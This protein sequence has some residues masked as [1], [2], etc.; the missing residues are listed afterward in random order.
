MEQKNRI[1][2][3]SYGYDM[4]FLVALLF[5]TMVHE[6]LASNSFNYFFGP[7]AFFSMVCAQ[8][9]LY[10]FMAMPFLSSGKHFRFAAVTV[11]YVIALILVFYLLDRYWPNQ[12]YHHGQRKS[13]KFI[14]YYVATCM[15]SS[16]M[17]IALSMVRQYYR[18]QEKR[19]KDQVLLSQ[20]A[21]QSLHSQ[22]NP[23]FFFNMLNNLYGVSL[24]DPKRTPDLI[25]QLSKLM[26]YPLEN[27]NRQLVSLLQE[28]EFVESYID[29]ERERSGSQCRISFVLP[30]DKEAVSVLAIAPLLLITLVENAFKHS[31]GSS[32]WFVKLHT[33]LDGNT[34]KLRL[35]NSLP[36]FGPK[37]ESTGIGLSNVRK[38]LD[39]LYPGRHT[40][41]NFSIA[42][43][44]TVFLVLQLTAL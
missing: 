2:L 18:E 40:F 13:M 16:I 23:H 4:F 17:L 42:E 24:T 19:T 25:L 35:S 37:V 12:D 32:D 30:V 21:I 6:W 15:F 3:G 11:I 5:L 44:Y 10:R 41:E 22:L 33:E 34:L 8:A 7:I 20:M 14:I 29:M 43:E 26:R 31:S 27:G 36:N 9:Y 38:R 39:L 28:L 1:Q